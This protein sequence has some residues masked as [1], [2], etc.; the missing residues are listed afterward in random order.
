M[1]NDEDVGRFANYYICPRCGLHW[2]DIWEATCDDDCPKCGCRHVSPYS[3]DD[4]DEFDDVI[5]DESR[6]WDD[7]VIV[8][9]HL[10]GG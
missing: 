1:A 9:E 8:P 4:V 2:T 10:R 6:A 7:D 3:S 5:G